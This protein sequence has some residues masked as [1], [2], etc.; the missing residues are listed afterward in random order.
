VPN[1]IINEGTLI[2]V[3]P[4]PF[5]NP[6]KVP[7]RRVKII[8][9]NE[10]LLST[11]KPP[12]AHEKAAIDPTDKSISP[13]II[14]I[15]IPKAI[16]PKTITVLIIF[17][18]LSKSKKAGLIKTAKQQRMKNNINKLILLPVLFNK[19]KFMKKTFPLIY[20]KE[21]VVIIQ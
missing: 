16:I 12:K 7:A 18:I 1:V 17:C 11:N 19:L 15:V 5:K 4:M 8:T 13:R 2:I 3:T 10:E 9:R 21:K 6:Q 14:T 20:F